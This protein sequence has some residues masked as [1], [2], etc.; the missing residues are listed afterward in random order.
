M[1]YHELLGLDENVVLDEMP[2]AHYQTVGNFDKASSFKHEDDRKI[3]TN[4]KAIAKLHK[5]FANNRFD[6]N[7][8]FV[9]VPGMGKHLET[10]VVDAEWIQQN[11][12][13]V[14]PEIQQNLSNNSINIIFTNN[15]ATPRYPMT[16]WIIAHRFGHAVDR[17]NKGKKTFDDIRR[18]CTDYAEQ[19]LQIYNTKLPAE[20]R[21]GYGYNQPAK[22]APTRTK[23]L[24]NLWKQIGG[25]K[26]ARDGT[27][28]DE[29]E[30]YHEMCAEYLITGE[31]KLRPI[32]G[33]LITGYSYGRPQTRHCAPGDQQYLN[34]LINDLGETLTNE[35]ENVV[36]S[37]VGSILVM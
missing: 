21:Y 14:W 20:Q 33:G 13:K 10:G 35:Y 11:M 18:T 2:V 16:A 6:F 28:R 25:M 3:L 1:R 31:I 19:I 9:N 34:S 17:Y 26:S 36:S 29:Y 12:P 23:T 32:E 7:M 27:L 30:F 37:M 5:K 4:P 24:H 22:G 15:S 8:F